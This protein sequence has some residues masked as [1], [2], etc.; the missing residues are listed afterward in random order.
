MTGCLLR[1][2]LALLLALALMGP[3]A[4]KRVERKFTVPLEPGEEEMMR[5]PPIIVDRL[6]N[7]RKLTPQEMNTNELNHWLEML[8][9]RRQRR[10]RQGGG[11]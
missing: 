8:E 11:K 1:V 2:A 10:D 4:A 6:D 5:Q 7:Y 9:K 3:A